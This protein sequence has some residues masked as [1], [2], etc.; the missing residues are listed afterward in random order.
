VKP[1]RTTNLP[2]LVRRNL[3]ISASEP[4]ALDLGDLRLGAP[5]VLVG[6]VVMLDGTPIPNVTVR[7]WLSLPSEDG[8]ERPSAVTLGEA[9]SDPTGRYRLLLPSSVAQ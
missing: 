1:E 5:A 9:T 4:Q 2:W 8:D 6:E 7:A 3:A